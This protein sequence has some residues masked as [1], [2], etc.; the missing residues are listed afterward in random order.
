MAAL[1][2]Q[3][4]VANGTAPTLGAASASDTAEVGNG[5]NTFAVYK[6]SG[7]SASVVTISVAGNTSYGEPLPDPAITVPITTGEKWIPLRKEYDSGDGTGRCTITA[8]NTAG[9]T[10]AIVRMA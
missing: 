7:G 2:T 8:T 10:V 5:I 1:T 6:N 3:N 4:I 9:L